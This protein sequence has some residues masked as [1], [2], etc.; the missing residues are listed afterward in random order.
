M[1]VRSRT[2]M[3]R[4]AI[5]GLTGML[6]AGGGLA[7]AQNASAAD[8]AEA[9]ATEAAAKDAAMDKAEP[10]TAKLKKPAKARFSLNA[11]ELAVLK[12]LAERRRQIDERE[13]RLVERERVVAV[14]ESRLADQAKEMKRLQAVL[15]RQSAEIEAAKQ[16]D[17]GAD[18]ARLTKLAKAY[19][20]MKPKDAARL[21]EA[22]D[23]A[24]LAP[25][26]REI[27]ARSLAPVLS[28]MSAE[29]ANELGRLL[30]RK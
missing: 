9:P 11:G 20:A 22:M 4:A 12:Q 30:R 27:A 6:L 23:M 1:T 28:R 2:L 8:E 5:V 24:M 10:E 26:A 7:L 18:K 29:K 15:A 14:M 17:M 3:K 19:K 25:I 21:F 13:A 16:A